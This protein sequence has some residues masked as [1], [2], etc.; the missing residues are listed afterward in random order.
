MPSPTAHQGQDVSFLDHTRRARRFSRWERG[1]CK[2]LTL[3]IGQ[4]SCQN[5]S[6]G[7]VSVCRWY[8]RAL[9][10]FRRRAREGIVTGDAVYQEGLA[11]VTLNGTGC[12]DIAWC[13][14]YAAVHRLR[15]SER[16][17]I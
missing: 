15:R 16:A 10:L 12:I 2:I 13:H 4:R 6:G 7:R 14:L 1:Q 3:P 11:R 8:G 17:C 5:F 9:S